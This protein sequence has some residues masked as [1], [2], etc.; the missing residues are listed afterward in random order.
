MK[1][2]LSHLRK[3]IAEELQLL[4]EAQMVDPLS[5]AVGTALIDAIKSPEF[6]NSVKSHMSGKR[7]DPDKAADELVGVMPQSQAF[8]QA[9]YSAIRSA[10]G[11]ENAVGGDLAKAHAAKSKQ[12]TQSPP[13]AQQSLSPGE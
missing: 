10:S 9:I 4:R 1:I 12:R 8:R 11:D 5:I 6:I 3:L 13:A 7:G 2:R